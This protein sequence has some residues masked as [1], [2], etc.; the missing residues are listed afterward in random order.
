MKSPLFAILRLFLLK[1]S[2]QVIIA[3]MMFVAMQL[4]ANDG[5]KA[6]KG[7]V[8]YIKKALFKHFKGIDL[9]RL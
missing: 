2:I 8:V 6:W 3:T 5:T 4:V 9:G 1:I 7:P